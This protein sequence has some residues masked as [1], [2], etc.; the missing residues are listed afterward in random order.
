[1]RS[2]N[3]ACTVHYG[4][5]GLQSHC[6]DSY[7]LESHC[8]GNMHLWK[9]LRFTA[10]TVTQCTALRDVHVQYTCICNCIFQVHKCQLS[11]IFLELDRDIVIWIVIENVFQK[12][13]FNHHL[14]F[15]FLLIQQRSNYNY[16]ERTD[17]FSH[18][19]LPE[20]IFCNTKSPWK[21]SKWHLCCL[22]AVHVHNPT[23]RTCTDARTLCALRNRIT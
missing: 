3:A 4:F 17:I 18:I 21:Y 19:G 9:R 11:S 12:K 7:C 6:L 13:M 15:L 14:P 5:F 22:T 23:T 20:Y 2:L 8:L 16:I 10:L 1:M